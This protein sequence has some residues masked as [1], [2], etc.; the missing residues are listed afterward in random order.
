MDLFVAETPQPFCHVL[1]Q[2]SPTNAKPR[3]FSLSR[4]F[5][6]VCAD[7]LWSGRT[8]RG[9]F[10]ERI[11]HSHFDS[12]PQLQNHIV[13]KCLVPTVVADTSKF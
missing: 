8:C 12:F 6:W 1:L 9:E 3:C 5:L 4:D 11:K 2:F 13:P 10:K 7:H